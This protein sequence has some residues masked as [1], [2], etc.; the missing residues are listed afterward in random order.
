[1]QI[2]IIKEEHKNEQR[3]SST[4][5]AIKLLERLGAEVFVEKGAGELS[6][7][8]DEMY[9]SAGAKIVDRSSCLKSDICLCVRMP[10]QNDISKMK[11]GSILIGILNPYENKGYLADLNKNNITSCCM[12]LIP[13]ISRAQ[14]MD[15]LSS[16]ANLS[17]YKSVID[18]AEKFSK[19]FPMMMTAAGRINPAKVMILGVGVAGLQ[20]IAT[21]KRLGAIV[22]AT[23][24]RSATKEQV[25]SLGGKFIMVE[26]E[27]SKE[28][29]TS[30]GYAKEMS[31]AYKKKQAILIAE[32][33]AKQDIVI[34]TALIPGKTAPVLISEDMVNSM[35]R[36][37]IIVDLAVE[38]GGNC[39]LSRIDEIVEH[40]GVKIIGY[41][42]VP[43]RVSKDASS[44]YSK[45][46][47]NFLALMINKEEKNIK[48]NWDDEIIN[49]V[50]LTHN[51]QVKL[52]K[53]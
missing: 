20:A 51:G 27:E 31:E 35:A 43:G 11:N 25:E 41:S 37:S 28:A 9:L 26:D 1:M 29:E 33:I 30:G 13:R 50:V 46:I 40:N 52:E 53:F 3:V 38:S 6:G 45:N 7:Y 32:T 39:P 44:L 22:S 49:S 24:V 8:D 10:S 5:E 23:D 14:S 18:A 36:G 19:A 21:A 34:C 17:G 42:N 15:V 4:P 2:S 47:V 48:I 12:E 16:Q